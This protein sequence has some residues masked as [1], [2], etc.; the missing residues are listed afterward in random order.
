MCIYPVTGG[1]APF[2]CMSCTN[3]CGMLRRIGPLVWSCYGWLGTGE[4]GCAAIGLSPSPAGVNC[5][6]CPGLTGTGTAQGIR[7]RCFSSQRPGHSPCTACASPPPPPCLGTALRKNRPLVPRSNSCTTLFYHGIGFF[8]VLVDAGQLF[9]C[10]GQHFMCVAT[11]PPSGGTLSVSH[12]RTYPLTPPPPA[13]DP[14][15]EA[16][17]P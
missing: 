13:L 12:R 14:F 15:P 3:V 11:G 5:G 17:S 8:M 10:A 4:L 2:H 9:R 7:R 16:T 6:D 1:T